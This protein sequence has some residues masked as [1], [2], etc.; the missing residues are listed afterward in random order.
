ME[1]DIRIRG[2]DIS[3]AQPNFDV[4]RA[5]EDGVKFLIIRA[6]ISTYTDTQ[7]EAHATGAEKAGLPYGFYWYSRAFSTEEAREEAKCCL[8]TI[9]KYS[10]VYPI[11]YDMEER[12]QIDW[13]TRKQRTDIICAFCEEIKKANYMAG[14]YLNPSWLEHYVEKDKILKNYYLWLAHWTE[15]PNRPTNYDYGQVI[16]QWGLDRIDGERIDGDICYRNFSACN[17]NPGDDTPG[18]GDK[19]DPEEDKMLPLGSIVRFSGG[20]QYPASNSDIGYPAGAG[21]VRIS[22]RAR[23]TLHPYHVISEDESGVYGWVD[24]DTLTS[25]DGEGE[26]FKAG[27]KIILNDAPLYAAAGADNQLNVISGVYYLYDGK[28]F[29]GYYRICPS[30]SNVNALPIAA[31]V[32][33]WVKKESIKIDC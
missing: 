16:W 2:I 15:S 30:E 17:N 26:K 28:D 19:P 6:G 7:L 27:E 22:N 23:G 11:F 20:K 13:L 5:K 33:G 3:Y 29:G 21:I 4:Q 9:K 8:D 12:D 10:P 1:K 25:L 31:N 32:T 24:S 14:V 18:G